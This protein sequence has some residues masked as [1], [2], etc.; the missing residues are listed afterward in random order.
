MDHVLFNVLQV[1]WRSFLSISQI[2][3]VQT[4]DVEE[5]I[6]KNIPIVYNLKEVTIGTKLVEMRLN[7]KAKLGFLSQI[8]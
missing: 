1:K 5:L 8:K 3:P 7:N 2:S 6:K 4:F